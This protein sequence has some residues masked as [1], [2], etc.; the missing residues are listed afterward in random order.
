MKEIFDLA[1]RWVSSFFILVMILFFIPVSGSGQ[2][3]YPCNDS[4]A[5]PG[6]CQEDRVTCF[7]I[8]DPVPLDNL[9][10]YLVA[11]GIGFGLYKL[12]SQRSRKMV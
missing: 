11:A 9:V 12:H 1:K 5:C 7:D 6:G 8:D 2:P 3:P 4:F 10:F